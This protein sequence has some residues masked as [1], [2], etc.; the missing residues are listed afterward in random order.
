MLNLINITFWISNFIR[1]TL[2]F[3]IL[4]SNESTNVIIFVVDNSSSAH[5]DNSK[6]DVLILN[7]N[8]MQGLGETTIIV[9]AKWSADITRSRKKHCLSLAYSRSNRYFMVIAG[10]YIDSDQQIL[11]KS[12]ILWV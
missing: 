3:F 2:F 12:H 9:E 11:I 4:N 5:T 7:E 10:K 8:S 1:L 6:K